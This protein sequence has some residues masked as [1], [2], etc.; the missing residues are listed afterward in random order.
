MPVRFVSS[1][2][3]RG[4]GDQVPLSETVPPSRTLSTPSKLLTFTFTRREE[5]DDD[6]LCTKKR[7][8]QSPGAK[9]IGGGGGEPPGRVWSG[10]PAR[11]PGTWV[12]RVHWGGA[13]PE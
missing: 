1:R 2:L 12:R 8:C 5:T 10:L 13:W 6:E 3:S 11:G 9:H 7:M 4:E